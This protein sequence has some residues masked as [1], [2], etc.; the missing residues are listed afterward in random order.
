[1]IDNVTVRKDHVFPNEKIVVFNFDVIN[2]QFLT[3]DDIK[4]T[5]DYNLFNWEEYRLSSL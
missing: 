2:L 5:K 3:E 4:T 1:M